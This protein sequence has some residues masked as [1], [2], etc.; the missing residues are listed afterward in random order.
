MPDIP[1]GKGAKM[2]AT[3][4]NVKPLAVAPPAGPNRKNKR[5]RTRVLPCSPAAI[6]IAFT[7]RYH[8][9]KFRDPH[10]CRK[11]ASNRGEAPPQ[12]RGRDAKKAAFSLIKLSLTLLNTSRFPQLKTNKKTGIDIGGSDDGT[13][14]GPQQLSAPSSREAR[15]GNAAA[16]ASRLKP[17]FLKGSRAYLVG[18]SCYLP[19]KEDF[20]HKTFMI[21]A[22]RKSVSFGLPFVGV[23]CMPVGERGE[24]L[25]G[26]EREGTAEEEV[27]SNCCRCSLVRFASPLEQVA[28]GKSSEGARI[29]IRA[30]RMYPRFGRRGREKTVPDPSRGRGSDSSERGESDA[31]KQQELGRR[32]DAGELPSGGQERLVGDKTRK[33]T[34]TGTKKKNS[35]SAPK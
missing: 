21:N 24:R 30:P 13:P 6:P 4:S 9:I 2:M 7:A 17:G 25:K 28:P 35:T 22:I 12:R 20:V 18:T 29:S 31:G 19:P 11:R 33:P 34:T 14:S 32:E 3:A 16:V 23:D 1:A 10:T 27:D 5:R 8:A 26:R 15:G